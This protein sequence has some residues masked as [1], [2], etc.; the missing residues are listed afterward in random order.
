M[1]CCR[2]FSTLSER[3]SDAKLRA[4][5]FAVS[6]VRAAERTNL[7]CVGVG[8]ASRGLTHAFPKMELTDEQQ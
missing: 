1:C 3:S 7:G 4:Q 2:P 6:S 5:Q 8:A